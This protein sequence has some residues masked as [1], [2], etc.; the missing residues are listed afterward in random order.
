MDNTAQIDHLLSEV[1][2]LKSR[3][4]IMLFRKMEQY[5]NEN[6]EIDAD[7]D[8]T[9]DSAFGLWKDSPVTLDLIRKKAYGTEQK[10]PL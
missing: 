9:I 6:A 7:E 3:E 2:Q 8:I 10:V 4:Q 5:L 1:K